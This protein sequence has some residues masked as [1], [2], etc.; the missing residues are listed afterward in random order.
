MKENQYFRVETKNHTKLVPANSY[1][2]AYADIVKLHPGIIVLAIIDYYD[3]YMSACRKG[4]ASWP[5]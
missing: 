1:A 4:L 2:Q 3:F 5:Q